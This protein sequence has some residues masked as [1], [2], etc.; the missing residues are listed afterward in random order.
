MHPS[1]NPFFNFL[2]IVF[3][4]R[5]L[6]VPCPVRLLVFKAQLSTRDQRVSFTDVSNNSEC[7]RGRLTS[8]DL[9]GR[10]SSGGTS[11]LL[12]VP[13]LSSTVSRERVGLVAPLTLSLG[14]L[15][16]FTSKQS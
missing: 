2:V 10:M 8:A 11:F 13:V 9:A 15:C 14:S 12:L 5:I 7:Q 4:Y 3:K 6:P 1:L 16:L